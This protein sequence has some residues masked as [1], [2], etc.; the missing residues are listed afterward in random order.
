MVAPKIVELREMSEEQLVQ[1]YDKIS[2]STIIGTDFYLQEI[3]RRNQNRQTET[4]LKY[5]RY[6]L[7]MT[8]A[9]TLATIVNVVIAGIL[10]TK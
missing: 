1:M 5:T 4:M 9:V 8:V 7:W 6:I 3:V 2:E 10:L